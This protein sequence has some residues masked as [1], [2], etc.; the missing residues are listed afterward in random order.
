[1]GCAAAAL[2][3][4]RPAAA[5]ASIVHPLLTAALLILNRDIATL[6]TRGMEEG[7]GATRAV[8]RGDAGQTEPDA[9][10]AGA[11]WPAAVALAC[12]IALALALRLV[13]VIFVPSINWGDEIFQTIEPA[14]RLIYGYGLMT[15]E[16]ELGMRSWL[17]PGML[18]V[19]IELSRVV[20]DGPE[21]Y[22]T[23]IA[24]GLG[25]LACATVAC[26]FLWARRWFGLAGGFVAAFAVA[27]APELVYFGARALNDVVAAHLLVIALYLIEPGRPVGD[28]RRLGAAGF[29]LGFVCLFR[30]QLAPAAAVVALWP[31]PGLWRR[32]VAALIAGGLAAILLG[33]VLDWLTLGYPLASVWRNLFYNVY[34]GIS[35]EFSVAPWWFYLLGEVGVWG[36]ATPFMLFLI[37]LGARRMPVDF[38][39][40]VAIV[41]VQAAI[42][43]KEYRFIYPAVLLMMVL[44][45]FGLAQVADWG[46]QWFIARGVRPNWIAP[47]CAAALMGWWAFL[48]YGVW[49]GGAIAALRT[50]AHDELTAIAFVR[51]LPQPCGIGL[52]GENAWVRYGGYSHLHRKLP[53]YWPPD[54]AELRAETPAFDALLYDTD[55]A[56]PPPD[57]GFSDIACFGQICVGRRPGQCETRPL[58]QPWFPERLRGT[59]PERRFEPVP[60]SIRPAGAAPPR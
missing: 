47:L 20:G 57:L 24:L 59:T 15:W 14:H 40:A 10:V 37:A 46:R 48:A 36:A 35:S 34:L 44:A 2:N 58:P 53:M 52:Y 33:A 41:A 3:R 31:S 19:L 26:C 11:R 56:R 8:L 7:V 49:S 23:G 4:R 60:E 9:G 12:L 32:R 45:A 50:R 42:P 21:Y 16:F 55:E 13:P 6:A 38:A 54:E 29:L 28:R 30:L 1:M 25:I 39:T 17:M 18:A 22:L 43:H 27:L 5:P 51:G